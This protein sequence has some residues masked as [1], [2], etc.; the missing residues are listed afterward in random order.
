MTQPGMGPDVVGPPGMDQPGMEPPGVEQPGD[1]MAD[2]PPPPPDPEKENMR[3]DTASALE[4]CLEYAETASQRS[5]CASSARPQIQEFERERQPVFE[6]NGNQPGVATEGQRRDR[7]GQEASSNDRNQGGGAQRAEGDQ[8]Q[9]VE[10]DQGDNRVAPPGSTPG[11]GIVPQAENVYRGNDWSNKVDRWVETTTIFDDDGNIVAIEKGQAQ[12]TDGQFEQPSMGPGAVGPPGMGPGAVGPPDPNEGNVERRRVAYDADGN[13]SVVL[14][15]DQEGNEIITEYDSDGRIT[16]KET[17]DEQGDLISAEIPTGAQAEVAA[18]RREVCAQGAQ[19]AAT[20]ICEQQLAER[21]RVMGGGPGPVDDRQ[22]FR[23]T[24]VGMEEVRAP[25]PGSLEY[26]EKLYGLDSGGVVVDKGGA[27]RRTQTVNKDGSLTIREFDENGEL[28]SSNTL[29]ARTA[30]GKAKLNV[31]DR[32]VGCEEGQDLAVCDQDRVGVVWPDDKPGAASAL[33]KAEG[34]GNYDDI[35]ENVVSREERSDDGSVK[36]RVTRYEDKGVVSP[37]FKPVKASGVTGSDAVEFIKAYTRN[38]EGKVQMKPEWANRTSYDAEGNVA[39]VENFSRSEDGKMSLVAEDRGNRQVVT[40]P[41]GN[42]T[43]RN[44]NNDPTEVRVE[45]G[46]GNWG[47]EIEYE[48]GKAPRVVVN[49]EI[50]G[51]EMN[52]AQD[53]GLDGF[54]LGFLPNYEKGV[55]DKKRS[56]N[57]EED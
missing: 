52:L 25:R 42:S 26:E 24:A 55:F 36:A 49:G 19:T 40:A 27:L 10:G 21:D 45:P 14:T 12:L 51:N 15:T 2:M 43:S 5:A 13:I 18:G 34:G 54:V 38:E 57:N 6:R 23:E 33:R 44:G 11:S 53:A 41:Q 32:L 1:P 30:D 35:V 8:G 47:Y 16:W 56:R 9:A 28:I 29:G 3:V 39:R 4:A 7:E 46:P 37:D 50:A 22:A 31:N 20:E 48:R 17:R